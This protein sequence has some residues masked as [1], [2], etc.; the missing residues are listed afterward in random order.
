LTWGS[1]DSLT[2]SQDFPAVR[3]HP[4]TGERVFFNQIHAHHRSFYECHPVFKGLKGDP[5]MANRW[6][7]HVSY[8]DG[9][10]IPQA[11][12]DHMR[13][14]I[15]KQCVGIRPTPGDIIVY[16]N[17]AALHGRMGYDSPQGTRKV[18]VSATFD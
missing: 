16:D 5:A 2:Y 12:L 8:S 9:E 1:D 15:W 11:H 6:P 7:V 13:S 3:E 18:Y 4:K 17:W 14:V 10:E